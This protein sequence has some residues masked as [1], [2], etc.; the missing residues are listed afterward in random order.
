MI[1]RKRNEMDKKIEGDERFDIILMF[2][3]VH[4]N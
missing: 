2:D 3:Y 1:K 4:M